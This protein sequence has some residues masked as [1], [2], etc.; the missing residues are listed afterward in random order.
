MKHFYGFI[1]PCNIYSSDYIKKNQNILLYK[2]LRLK[3]YND[4]DKEFINIVLSE[5][6][7]MRTM[8]TKRFKIIKTYKKLKYYTRYFKNIKENKQNG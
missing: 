2:V 7:S 3:Y 5:C 4:R 6:M 8:L 1:K